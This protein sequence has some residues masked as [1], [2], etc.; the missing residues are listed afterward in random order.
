[1]TKNQ[2]TKRKCGDFLDHS[3][4]TSSS[5]CLFNENDKLYEVVFEIKAAVF[6][7]IDGLNVVDIENTEELSKLEIS[8]NELEEDKSLFLFMHQNT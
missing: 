5:E 6:D 7:L 8:V 1:M 3:F 2:K 4:N